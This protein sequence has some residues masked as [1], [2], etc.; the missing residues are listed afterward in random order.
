L[1]RT[2]RIFFIR[3]NRKRT[4]TESVPAFAG[5]GR[6]GEIMGEHVYQLAKRTRSTIFRRI[7]VHTVRTTINNPGKSPDAVDLLR[8]AQLQ[9]RCPEHE[10]TSNGL[11]Q[12]RNIFLGGG[13]QMS[14][15]ENARGTSL[16]DG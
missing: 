4:A 5:G 14:T 2:R 16:Y 8:R 13:F 12:Q 3:E 1:D 6:G 10:T 11:G 9:T 7:V 15:I